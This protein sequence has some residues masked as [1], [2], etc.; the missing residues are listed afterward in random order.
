MLK[1]SVEVGNA[2][3]RKQM[4][5]NVGLLLHGKKTL[6]ASKEATTSANMWA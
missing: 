2:N 4:K 1:K 5:S 6:G 3:K